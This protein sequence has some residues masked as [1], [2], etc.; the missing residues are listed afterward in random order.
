MCVCYTLTEHSTQS[1]SMV[2]ALGRSYLMKR[3][4]KWMV[5]FVN[6][7]VVCPVV[8]NKKSPAPI[9]TLVLGTAV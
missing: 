1:A 3:S 5:V 7:I 6:R 4:V 9:V 8:A 2:D